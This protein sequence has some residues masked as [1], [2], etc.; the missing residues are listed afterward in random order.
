M[1]NLPLVSVDRQLYLSL[2]ELDSHY[3]GFNNAEFNWTLTEIGF[4]P[5]DIAEAQLFSLLSNL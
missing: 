4:V 5:S 1:L 2:C 3:S